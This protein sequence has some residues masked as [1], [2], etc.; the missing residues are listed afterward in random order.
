MS[1]TKHQRPRARAL[2]SRGSVWWRRR[3]GPLCACRG[4]RIEASEDVDRRR[5]LEQ[6][7]AAADVRAEV[8]R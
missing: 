7:A 5:R 1:G 8:G 6:R 3:R 4:C 2:P